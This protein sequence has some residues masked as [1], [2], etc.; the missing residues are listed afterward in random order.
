MII[1]FRK[2]KVK[3]IVHWQLAYM[4]FNNK[5]LN[6]RFSS[7]KSMYLEVKMFRYK[8]FHQNLTQTIQMAIT[9]PIF[10]FSFIGFVIN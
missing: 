4:S 1:H 10:F 8:T 9:Q 3:R 6:C 2:K 5:L 7:I